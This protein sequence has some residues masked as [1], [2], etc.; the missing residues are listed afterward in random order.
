M[1]LQCN[2]QYCQATCLIPVA[3]DPLW[4]FSVLQ[5]SSEIMHF[6]NGIALTSILFY[7]HIKKFILLHSL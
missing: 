6:F 4:K 1:K 3:S 2:M 7:L 5:D